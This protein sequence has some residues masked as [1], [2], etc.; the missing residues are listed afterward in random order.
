MNWNNP[1]KLIVLFVCV[2]IMAAP[3]FADTEAQKNLR[4]AIYD[5]YGITVYDY[6]ESGGSTFDERHLKAMIE[7]FRDMPPAFTSCTKMVFMDPGN[8]QFE[9]KYNGYNEEAGIIQLGY[10]YK[11]PSPIFRR[12]FKEIYNADPTADDFLLNFKTMLVRGMA[13][14]FIQ[15][16]TDAWGKS[17]L[18]D[19]YQVIYAGDTTFKFQN[20]ALGDENYMVVAPGKSHLWTDL[21]FAVAQY[22]TNASGL[23]KDHLCRQ[24]SFFE[25]NGRRHV[26]KRIV[27]LQTVAKHYFGPD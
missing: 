4:E 13:Y 2:A 23:K 7:V 15:E 6:A 5:T 16:N 12:K 20:Y 24:L 10:A 27:L 14:C 22:C 3:I 19:K 8:D 21:A 9:I 11:N 18:M 1:L 25:K 17:E 26:Q